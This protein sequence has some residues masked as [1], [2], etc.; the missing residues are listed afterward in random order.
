LS[1]DKSVDSVTLSQDG[2]QTMLNLDTGESVPL[3]LVQ[4]IM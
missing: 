1:L 4:R 3:S 2:E